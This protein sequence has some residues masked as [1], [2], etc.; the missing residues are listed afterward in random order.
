MSMS[1]KKGAMGRLQRLLLMHYTK[2]ELEAFKLMKEID[3]NYALLVSLVGHEIEK[4]MKATNLSDRI[5]QAEALRLNR[6]WQNVL[7]SHPELKEFSEKQLATHLMTVD[8]A[9]TYSLDTHL[10]A[11]SMANQKALKDALE[12]AYKK[13]FL[14]VAYEIQQ[15]AGVYQEVHNPH[16]VAQLITKAWIGHE[17]FISRFTK[18]K[19]K[20]LK[21]LEVIFRQG[22]LNNI[23][24]QQLA[25]QYAKRV[26]VSQ[27][28]AKRLVL[29]EMS[30]IY[31]QATADAYEANGVEE[32]EILA[33]LD[34]RTS[35]I[36]QNLDGQRF[37]VDEKQV[38]VNYPPFHPVCRTTTVPVI[39]RFSTSS[40]KRW[41]KD[42]NGV[43]HKVDNMTYNEWSNKY[44]KN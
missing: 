27:T 22:Y 1:K 38:G 4:A 6:D 35:P 3:N 18:D 36:C 11:T 29:T 44:L 17:N 5:T 14:L 7:N 41:S 15:A 30:N 12:T 19:E 40:S 33:T 39:N 28:S 20:T 13:S 31:G 25:V 42:E 16:H 21:E 43:R 10:T 37:R 23:P 8:Q 9:L 26:G 32:Y 2:N 34:N 24:P